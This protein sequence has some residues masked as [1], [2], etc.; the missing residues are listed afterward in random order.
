M[1]IETGHGI[2]S[3][4]EKALQKIVAGAI[5]ETEGVALTANESAS[6]PE[7]LRAAGRNGRIALRMGEAGLEIEL[8]IDVR[9]GMRIQEVCR[10]LRDNVR[11]SVEKLAGLP[12]HVI[13]VAVEGLSGTRA[14]RVGG[15]FSV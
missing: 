1:K 6:L 11:L 2:I 5:A 7:R 3:I 15:A 12:V 9:F 10:K 4:T 13:E 14:D 8:R